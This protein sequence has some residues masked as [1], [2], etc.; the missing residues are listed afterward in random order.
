MKT[1]RQNNVLTSS[2][3]ATAAVG[4]RGLKLKARKEVASTKDITDISN[5]IKD[6]V[7][8]DDVIAVYASITTS[9]VFWHCIVRNH[10]SCFLFVTKSSECLVLIICD[11]MIVYVY[12]LSYHY[13]I[14]NGSSWPALVTSFIA[15]PMQ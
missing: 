5:Q 10:I 6:I 4:I 2:S 11:Y 13:T 7:D 15:M 12:G 9:A 3:I 8:L 1:E 14:L